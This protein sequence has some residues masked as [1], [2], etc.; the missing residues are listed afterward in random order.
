MECS[1]ASLTFPDI[2]QHFQCFPNSQALLLS[3]VFRLVKFVNSM[4]AT[5]SVFERS[6]SHLQ[7]IKTYLHNTLTQSYSN[8]LMVI[9]IHKNLTDSIT[10]LQVINE[11][12]SAIEEKIRHYEHVRNKPCC[13]RMLGSFCELLSFCAKHRLD[14]EVKGFV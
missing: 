4:P 8:N 11:F 10:H 14:S 1:G 12:S 7:I 5:N 6:A 9:H 2:C 3:Q 13:N